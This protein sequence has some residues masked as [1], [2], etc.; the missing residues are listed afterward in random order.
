MNHMI[1]DKTR[2]QT[3]HPDDDDPYHKWQSSRIDARKCL[4]AEDNGSGREAELGEDIED[5]V[6]R[7]SDVAGA[8]AGD[9]HSAQAGLWS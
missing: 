4:S 1:A 6:N 9:D 7:T 5:G 2:D 8:E 3:A